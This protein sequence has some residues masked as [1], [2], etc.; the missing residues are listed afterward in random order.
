MRIRKSVPEGYKTGAKYSAFTLFSDPSSSPPVSYARSQSNPELGERRGS[1]G[2]R[3]RARELEPFCG[4]NK[5]GGLLDQQEWNSQYSS[6]RG[7]D[8]DFD[9]GDEDDVPFLSSQGST[10]SDVSVQSVMSGNGARGNKRTWEEEDDTF[11]LPDRMEFG[12]RPMAIPRRMKKDKEN[13]KGWG[14]VGQ[15]NAGMDFGEAEFLD[16]EGLVEGEVEMGGV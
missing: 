3:P 9:V 4:I 6:R 1:G 8:L 13:M 2:G 14:A 7:Q 11:V 5:I 16:Y 12:Q 10:I 15:E